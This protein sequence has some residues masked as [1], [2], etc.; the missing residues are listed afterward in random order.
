MKRTVLVVEDEPEVR[1]GLRTVLEAEGFGVVEAADG[2]AA[3]AAVRRATPDCVILDLMLP[4]LDGFGVCRALR[5]AGATVPILVL[6]ARGAESDKVL[7]LEVGADDYVTKPFSVREVVA[8]V[9][10]L[11]RRTA[12]SSDVPTRVTLGGATV[13]LVRG[14]ITRGRHTE[15]LHHYELEILRVLLRRAD[16]A[17][18]RADLL[19]EVWGLDDAPDTRTVD[20]H[21]H[22][23]RQKLERDPAA[24][25][26]VLTAHGVGYRLVR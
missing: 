9:R 5:G 2:R 7:G 8:R 18:S 13:D 20:F 17:V 24:P 19:R 1:A 12:D 22:S 15:T 10:A 14:K 6:S 26:H 23:L 3:V 4:G 16:T 11:L 25:A 21:V